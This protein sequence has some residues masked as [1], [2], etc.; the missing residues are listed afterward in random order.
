[1]THFIAYL[2][3]IQFTYYKYKFV[4]LYD[5]NTLSETILSFDEFINKFPPVFFSMVGTPLGHLSYYETLQY[6]TNKD[7]Y[8]QLI[9]N[10]NSL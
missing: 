5:T 9:K 1:M 3:E 6:T 2:E 8:Y 4:K 10:N 7:I